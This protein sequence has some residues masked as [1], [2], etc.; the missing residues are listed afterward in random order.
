LLTKRG[1]RRFQSETPDHP[2]LILIKGYFNKEDRF[3]DVSTFTRLASPGI[4]SAIVFLD[5]TG[6]LVWT[7]IDIGTIIRQ[8][9]FSTAVADNASCASACAL[10]WMGG[11]ERFMGNDARI[12]FHAA[13]NVVTSEVSSGAN[14]AVGAYLHEVGVKNFNTVVY[15]TSA[16]PN[17]MRWLTPTDAIRYGIA[18]THFGFSQDGW[19]W[20]RVALMTP[21]YGPPGRID[22]P[23]HYPSA[24]TYSERTQTQVEKSAEPQQH[25]DLIVRALRRI[26]DGDVATAREILAAADDGSQGLASFALA[27]TYDPNMLAAWGIHGVASDVA[28]ARE[29]Y[30]KALNLGVA[31]AYER[32]EALK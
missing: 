29:L 13:R 5:S 21:G 19:A 25:N 30:R 11:K 18:V 22:A 9:R 32:L 24:G 7:A 12:G 1:R 16:S 6:G 28:R 15:L 17:S 27:E 26:N 10:V 4:N 23:G 2:A 31:S 14:A 20:A 8:R 3:K